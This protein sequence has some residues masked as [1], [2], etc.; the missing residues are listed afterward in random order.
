M[1]HKERRGKLKVMYGELPLSKYSFADIFN[2][3]KHVIATYT[4]IN[5][6]LIHV[7][8]LKHSN[9]AKQYAR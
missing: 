5:T 2:Y 7:R 1:A 4:V 6:I 8:N 9:D 3:G